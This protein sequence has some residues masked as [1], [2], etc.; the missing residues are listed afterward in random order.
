[1]KALIVDELGG[2]EKLSYR[3]VPD[4]VPTKG[5]VLISVKAAGVNFPDLLMVQGR[6]QAS[7]PPPFSPG[8]EVAGV[9]EAIGAGVSRV[10]VGD[11]VAGMGLWGG[12]AESM[13]LGEAQVMPLPDDI[14]FEV[15][16]A[17]TVTYGT[18][19]HALEDRA[20]LRAGQ[21]VLVLG[22]AGGVGTAAIEIA[23][24]MGAK[25]IAAASS[26]EK[27]EVCRQLGADEVIDYEKEDLK[28]RAK[29]LSGGG[30]D[31]VVDPVGGRYSEPAL[32]AMAW[33]GR[34]L[35]LGFASGDIPKVSLNLPLL[36]GCAIVGVYWGSFAAHEPA[37]A[38]AQLARIGRWVS[39]GKLRPHISKTYPLA[40]GRA[41]LEDLAARR[42]T[43]KL[44][45]VP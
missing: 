34:F 6:Y 29:K 9:V 27:L 24:L 7:P 42:A 4:P 17:V 30:V 40:E 8:G 36:K 14:S 1:M 39:E 18:C 5:E 10:K 11:R 25:V 12:F 21:T 33:G 32:R 38:V 15:G 16:A 22:A 43:G 45:L 13:V 31:V 37:K 19:L 3:E 41:A 35:V 23:K 2:P 44:V 26:P 28:E 20:Q